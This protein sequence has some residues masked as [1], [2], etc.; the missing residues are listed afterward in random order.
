MIQ[1]VMFIVAFALVACL[2]EV[3][4]KLINKKKNK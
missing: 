3:V 4:I 2:A 1:L